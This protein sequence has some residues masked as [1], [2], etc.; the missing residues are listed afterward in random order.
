MFAH[1]RTVGTGLGYKPLDSM[2][3]FACYHCHQVQEGKINTPMMPKEVKARII[4][5]LA[6]TH[7]FLVA[8]GHM[9]LK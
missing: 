9:V 1:I 5:G 4:A 8:N 6:E 7:A 3:V 2:G